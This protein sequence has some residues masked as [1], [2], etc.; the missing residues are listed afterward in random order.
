MET[1]NMSNFLLISLLK[2]YGI[3]KLVLSSGTRNI[4]FVT[5]VEI[6]DFFECFSVV[7]ERNAAFFGLG[8]CQQ[9]NEPVAIVC[10]SGTAASNYLTGVTEAYYS[11]APLVVITYDR[12][13]Y[14]LHQ[15][16]TQKIDQLSIFTSVVKKSVSLPVVKDADDVWYCQRLL[17]EAFICLKQHLS[18]PVHIN[19]PLVG[20]TNAL[21]NESFK[22][23][24]NVQARKINY[25]A[26]DDHEI[27]Q[28]MA[29]IL[30]SKKRII[31]V[32]GQDCSE[33]ANLHQALAQYC[34]HA[35][36]PI[37][38]DNLSNFRCSQMIWAEPII[39]ALNAKSIEEL[40][41]EVVITFGNN[42]QERIKDLLKAHQGK[43]EHWSID[44]EGV[45]RDVFKSQTA[46]FECK[47]SYFFSYFTQNVNPTD[48]TYCH[49]WQELADAIK[50][51]EM[52]FTNF[53]AIKE[54]SRVIPKESILHLSIL[55]ATRLTQ[56]F[57]IDPSVKVYSNVNS[58]GID[59]CL[60]TFIGQSV[61]TDK[62][63]F[64]VIGDLSFFYGMNAIAIN[65][66]KNNIRIMLIN[67]G[68]GAEFHIV[69]SSN[70][71]P[72][73]D[74]H[75]GAAHNYN[76]QGWAES[77]EYKYL[78]A[79]DKE[80]LAVALDEFV[81]TDY[82]YPVLLEIFTNLKIDGEFCLSVYREAEK[83]ITPLL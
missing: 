51:P 29:Q 47:P 63:S 15:L 48:S 32:M 52:P 54:F 70:A 79:N 14:T 17:N 31:I 5:A 39:K 7:D 11:H 40:L 19:I 26:L 76:A 62:I 67:N 45:V 37:L 50:L 4:P 60:P 55:N 24:N 25:V 23:M 64:L 35:Q 57:N 3:K 20:D 58:F 75:I 28:E 78:R 82:N 41:P 18:G 83:C 69:P 72:T 34:S 81:C 46:L 68:G 61:A 53:Y 65:H 10:T 59:G 12:S 21:W 13:P 73:I 1:T 6:D 66:K 22:K 80:S 42:F 74:K 30:S 77:M 33:D 38:L 36:V 27:W 56:F 8:L 2:Q 9:L 16:E 49:R 44:Q 71:I 43:F